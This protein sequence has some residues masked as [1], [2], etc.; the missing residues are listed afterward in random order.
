MSYSLS[1]VSQ[2]LQFIYN[3]VS[4]SQHARWAWLHADQSAAFACTCCTLTSRYTQMTC[5][6][7]HESIY[8]VHSQNRKDK[9]RQ[10]K[11]R[12]KC[13]HCMWLCMIKGSA[14]TMGKALRLWHW[15]FWASKQYGYIES[16]RPVVLYFCNQ[17]RNLPS[18]WDRCPNPSRWDGCP[19]WWQGFCQ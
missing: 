14:C 1:P 4:L 12:N 13:T 8:S 10:E 5:A 19:N 7:Q 15:E 2:N 6:Q 16:N 9:K 18:R 17:P 11:S 3:K